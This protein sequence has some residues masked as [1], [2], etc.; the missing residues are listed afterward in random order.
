MNLSFQ[1]SNGIEDDASVHDAIVISL[2]AEIEER[3]KVIEQESAALQPEKNP[4]TNTSDNT[5]ATAQI[6][7]Q[8]QMAEAAAVA[9]AAASAVNNVVVT[10]ST[11]VDNIVSLSTNV[12]NEVS[13]ETPKFKKSSLSSHG[14]NYRK[15]SHEED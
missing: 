14:R 2:Q 6:S 12:E 3:E 9:A 13:K 1:S 11:N 10:L 5:S 15:R 7:D 8:N 4:T